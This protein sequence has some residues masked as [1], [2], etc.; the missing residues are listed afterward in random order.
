MAAGLRLQIGTDWVLRLWL[1]NFDKPGMYQCL[2][3]ES[4]KRKLHLE[5]ARK[6]TEKYSRQR[7]RNRLYLPISRLDNNYGSHPSEPDISDDELKRLCH[8]YIERLRV[9]P[10]EAKI[11]PKKTADQSADVD[12]MWEAQ[13]RGQITASNFGDACKRKTSMS[14]LTKRMNALK[15]RTLATKMSL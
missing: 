12:H 15:C 7:M 6:T 2:I 8:E 3:E 5:C 11:I 9:P 10:V 13:R 1:D 14:G 4:R